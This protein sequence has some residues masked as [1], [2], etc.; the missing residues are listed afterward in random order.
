MGFG[1]ILNAQGVAWRA[2]G[3]GVSGGVEVNWRGIGPR[4]RQQRGWERGAVGAA[5]RAGFPLNKIALAGEGG[6][7]GCVL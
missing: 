4:L 1:L 7:G 6:G 2:D 5:L 3:S